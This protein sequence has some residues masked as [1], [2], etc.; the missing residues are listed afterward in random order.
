MKTLFVHIGQMKT[1]T[2][3]LQ[4]FLGGNEAA[5]A[6]RGFSYPDIKYG[7]VPSVLMRNAHFLEL[8]FRTEGGD[9]TEEEKAE[10]LEGGMA[11]LSAALDA[12]DNV[13][14]SEEHLWHFPWMDNLAAFRAL[15]GLCE[16][17]GADLKLIV[18]LRRQD[19][20]ITS[21]RS[22]LIKET[23]NAL[24]AYT[25]LPWRDWAEGPQGI[26]IDYHSWLTEIASVVGKENIIVRPYDK[27]VLGSSEDGLYAD[28][29]GCMGL[30]MAGFSIPTKNLNTTLTPN[31]AEIHRLA[32]TSRRFRGDPTDTLHKAA[33]IC[34]RNTPRTAPDGSPLRTQ[35]MFAPEEARAFLERFE[36]GNRLI[37]R[38]Y[39]HTDGPLFDMHIADTDK[40]RPV[41]DDMR[42]DITRYFNTVFLLQ[43]CR[44][45]DSKPMRFERR[46]ASR[47]R[48]V[49]ETMLEVERE[50]LAI[51]QGQNQ[52]VRM[53]RKADKGIVRYL[54]E[55]YLL[56]ERAL[57]AGATPGEIAAI[58]DERLPLAAPFRAK[59]AAN[60][61]LR[62][63]AARF[64]RHPLRTARRLVSGE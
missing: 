41:N 53:R 56:R 21:L 55:V 54:T 27:E 7:D 1:G 4:R 30:D 58:T 36:E 59:V 63:R 34:S 6:A 47:R 9:E 57:R 2:T 45:I 18:Y 19:L 48:A 29:L 51:G 14:L 60:R 24:R 11:R 13:I 17:K 46:E 42:A 33:V 16:E 22:Q 28:F 62:A 10:I 44:I 35:T 32:V 20:F 5:L 37:A 26:I 40:W 61:T 23:N 52:G 31:I 50:L 12:T 64:L 3:N 39:L 43:E 38:E 15:T 8:A 49:P 25:K